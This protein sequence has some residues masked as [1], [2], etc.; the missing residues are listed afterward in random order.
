[1]AKSLVSQFTKP[2]DT[3]YDPFSGAGTVAL[4]SWMAGRNVIASDLSPYAFVLSKAK[5][6]PPINIQETIKCLDK[7]WLMAIEEQKQIDLRQV[8]KWVRSFFHPDTLREALAIRN[9]LLHHR[10]WFLLSCLLGILHHWRPGFLSYPCSHTVPY[11]KSKLYPRSSHPELYSYREVYPR[12]LAKVQRAFKR[13]PYLNRQLLRKTKLS[14]AVSTVSICNIRKVSAIITSP[15]YMNSLSYA[16]DNRLRLW[17]LGV[18]DHKKLEPALSP[19]KSEFLA[20]MQRLLLIWSKL[21][22]KN[23]HCILVLGAVRKGGKYHD[24]PAEILDIAKNMRCG[25]H[26]TAICKNVIPDI[27]RARIN[28][29]STREDTILVFRKRK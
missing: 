23:G 20:M 29:C 10:Q 15:P 4:E 7:Y 8:P 18:N 24:L 5:T 13:V 12:L 2:G 14:D 6:S 27:R 9:V 1:M 22:V 3:I 11:L 19:R 28:C 25:L 16:R 21:L 26:L 17:F